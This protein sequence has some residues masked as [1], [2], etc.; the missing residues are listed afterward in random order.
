MRS[1]HSHN[2]SFYWL[3]STLRK[4]GRFYLLGTEPRWKVG[5]LGPPLFPGNAPKT[6]LSHLSSGGS[7]PAFRDS[8]RTQKC[9]AVLS[10]RPFCDDENV[11]SV[12]SGSHMWLLS[13]TNAATVTKELNFQFH[14]I[15]VHLGPHRNSRTC[16]GDPH[17]GQHR[18]SERKSLARRKHSAN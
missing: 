14:L 2:Q 15:L 17:M 16:L 9:R 8:G 6:C 13:A 1:P 5:P 11:L 18:P 3:H 10:K 7:S 4:Q 12:Q